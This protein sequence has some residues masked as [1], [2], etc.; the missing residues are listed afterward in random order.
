MTTTS[1]VPAAPDTVETP[2]ANAIFLVM[3]AVGALALIS[4]VAVGMMTSVSRNE[5]GYMASTDGPIGSLAFVALSLP[6]H[7]LIG[8]YERRAQL[9]AA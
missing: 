4:S 9:V 5:E 2:K 1:S 7:A 6:V 8:R 3:L